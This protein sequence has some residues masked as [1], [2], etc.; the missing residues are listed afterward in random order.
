MSILRITGGN[1]LYGDIQ[2]QGAKNSVLPLMAASLLTGGETVLHGCPSLSDV[3]AAMRILRHLGCRAEKQGDTVTIDSATLTQCH[4]PHG[5]MREMRSSVI[6]LG[7][8]LAR[9]GEAVLSSPGGCELGPRPIDLHLMAMRALGAEIDERGGNLHCRAGTLTGTHID[10][11][12]PSVGATENSILAAAGAK[13]RTVI[14]GAA[15]EPEIRDLADF[16]RKLGVSVTGAGTSV[17]TVEPGT[18]VHRVE[19]TVIPDRIVAATYMSCVAAAGGKIKLLGIIPE[20]ISAVSQVFS[21]MGAEILTGAD[22][23][24]INVPGPLQAA[25]PVVTRP[26]PGFPTDA[27]PPLM[28]ASLVAQGVTVFAETIFENRY[29]HVPELR[30]LGADIRVDGRVA[31]VHGVGKLTGASVSATD[32][33][34]GAA[35]CVAGLAAEGTTEVWEIRHIERGYDSLDRALRTLGADVQ[36]IDGP[37]GG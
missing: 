5:L 16:L 32:L 18:L 33:R 22:S 28:A 1:R 20:D 17:V 4:I 12:T 14:T 25:G 36:K 34:G 37:S 11:A 15:R 31:E 24:T 2:V 13:G 27:Q 29:R 23:L 9:C 7:A 21:E 26:H 35:L 6:F 8:I 3:E 19:H 10:L 30:R